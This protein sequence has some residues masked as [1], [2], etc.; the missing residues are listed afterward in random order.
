MLYQV[1]A[2]TWSQMCPISSLYSHTGCWSCWHWFEVVVLDFVRLTWSLSYWRAN[3]DLNPLKGSILGASLVSFPFTV[4]VLIVWLWLKLYKSVRATI[5]LHQN[6]EEFAFNFSAAHFKALC[7]TDIL[8]YMSWVI[9]CHKL[10]HY[11]KHLEKFPSIFKGH[12]IFRN[13][14]HRN[15][16]CLSIY[17]LNWRAHVHFNCGG[18]LPK[19][20][21][22]MKDCP[23]KVPLQ[24]E[25]SSKVF[26]SQK[27][28]KQMNMTWPC[29]WNL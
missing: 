10:V 15:E 23:L 27:Q 14:H 5:C 25:D 18:L 3:T 28:N 16:P 20:P 6:F 17:A 21:F 4:K 19:L 22:T 13:T 2:G 29:S 24:F 7:V 26:P 12:L 11:E 8:G 1:L 9:Y